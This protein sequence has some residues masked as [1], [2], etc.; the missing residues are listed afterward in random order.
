[1]GALFEVRIRGKSRIPV[2]DSRAERVQTRGSHWP[3]GR[4]EKP[5]ARSFIRPYR[6]P[7]LVG[8]ENSL[9]VNERSS[10]KELGKLTPYLWKKGCLSSEAARQQ[11]EEVAKNRLKRLFTKNTGLCQRASGSI[12]ADSCPVPEGYEEW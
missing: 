11:R 5:L 4:Q 9:Q 7:T 2:H 6:K 1:M 10:V 3:P 8:K 12:G